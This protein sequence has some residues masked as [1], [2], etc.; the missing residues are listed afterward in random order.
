MNRTDPDRSEAELTALAD[1]TL[2]DSRRAEVEAR[3]SADPELAARLAE[4][5]RAVALMRAA[6]ESVAAP[7]SLRARV[8][9][10]RRPH[11][12][13]R[14]TLVFAGGL[15][16]AVAAAAALVLTL[17]GGPGAPTVA[18][19]ATLTVLPATAPAPA[20]RPGQPR[21]LAASVDGVAFPNYRAKFGWRATGR[22]SQELRGR[23][24]SVV[25]YRKGGQRIGYGIVA[26]NALPPPHEAAT[27]TRGGVKFRTFTQGGRSVVTWLRLGRTCVLSGRGVPTQTLLQLASWKGKGAVPF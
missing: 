10:A 15:A 9:A 26:G 21:L 11:P 17:P 27:V 1:G 14:K 20:A 19:A 13:R 8:E 23:D 12:R 16:A 24:T 6:A 2:S 18:E 25:Y 4:Q 7:L 5:R 3:V 22:R